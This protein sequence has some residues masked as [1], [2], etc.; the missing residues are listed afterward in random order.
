MVNAKYTGMKI[1]TLLVIFFCL[2]AVNGFSQRDGSVR[3]KL[4]DTTGGMPVADATVTVLDGRDSSLVSFARSNVSG[5]VIVKGLSKGSYRLLVTH[6]GYRS[7]SRPFMITDLVK[8]PDLG[9]LILTDASTILA[10]VTVTQEAA[11]VTIKHDTIEF[12][13]GSFKTKPEAVVEDL[14]KKLPGIQ[15]DKNGNIKAGGEAVKKVLV[16]GKEFFGNDPKIASKNLPADAVDKVQVFDKKSDQSQFTGFDDGNSQKTIN[17]TIKKDK[18][19][20]VFGKAIAGGGRDAGNGWAG[21]SGNGAAGGGTGSGDPLTGTSSRDGRYEGRFNLNQFRGNRQFSVLGMANNTNK[22]G[23]SFQDVLGFKGGMPGSGGGGIN[24]GGSSNPSSSGVPIEG[25]TDN[26]QAISTTLAGGLN[27]SDDWRGH[28]EVTGNYFYNQTDDRADQRYSR[29]YVTPGNSFRQDEV[30]ATTRHNGNQRLSMNADHRIDSFNSVKF[31]SAVT[32]QRSNSRSRITDSS[33]SQETGDLLN[34]GSSDSYS[35]ANG[36]TWNSNALFRH[37]MAKKGRTLSLNL[38]LGINSNTGSGSLYAVNEFYKAGQ[39][40]TIDTL[41]QVF[42]QPARG[43]N[44]GATL[45]YTE[46]LSRRSLLEFNYAFYQ[47]HS[48]S[49]KKTFDADGMGKYTQPNA[50]L[51]NTFSNLY[52]YHQEGIGF[53][54][55]RAAYNFTAGATLQQASSGNEFHYFAKDS[56]VG[57]SFVNILPNANFQYN[58]SGYSNLRVFYNTYTNQPGI[59][60]LQPVPDNSDPLNIREGNPGLKPEYYHS[61]RAHYTAFD[62]FRR[63]SLF[64]MLNYTGIHHRIVNDYELDSVGVRISRPVNMDGLYQLNSNLSWGFPLRAIRSNLNLNSS[65]VYDHNGSLVNGLRNISNNWTLSQGAELNFLYKEILDITGGVTLNYNDTRYSLQAG[66]NQHYW[67][68]H[69]TVDLN[70]YLPKGFSIASDM[71][72]I[73]RNGL[74]AGY[75]SSPLIWNAGL[76][77]TLTK[78]KKATLRLQVFDLLKQNTGFT[79]N[80]NQNYIEDVSYRTLNRYWMLSLTYNFSRF[81][82]KSV[83]GAGGQGKMDVKIVR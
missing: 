31:T 36:Y 57:Q 29:Q 12:N 58:F 49:D 76:A 64:F 51:T 1:N 35:D 21:S 78:S 77:K 62:P 44:Y 41:N 32:Y 6:V 82:G 38:S 18:K 28:T 33:R 7:L 66:Q 9:E 37:R 25:L 39:P 24:M 23:F 11:P 19:Y 56:S 42:D 59:T 74:P 50:Q 46:P 47:S 2:L 81:A 15:V 16:D 3:A 34:T 30:N 27:F 72:Y 69:Y 60:Q 45:A 80:T 40:F 55:Q 4:K 22:Q 65:A 13:A 79:R 10:G 63:T 43:H 20:G 52:T 70:A 17:L 48:R 71:D 8:D 14:L 53:R 26:N 75:N 54:H 73:H 68:Q 5:S 83:Q 61:L 67:T